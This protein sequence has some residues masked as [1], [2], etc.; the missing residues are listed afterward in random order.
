MNILDR[1][2]YKIIRLNNSQEKQIYQDIY[3]SLRT[4][5]SYL[6]DKTNNSESNLIERIHFDIETF[7]EYKSIN[8]YTTLNN[9]KIKFLLEFKLYNNHYEFMFP[10][11]R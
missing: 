2:K 8:F 10:N 3:D 7:Y 4:S 11:G 5:I 6:A 9:H 1:L